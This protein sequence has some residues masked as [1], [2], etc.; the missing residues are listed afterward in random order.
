MMP[1]V[2]IAERFGGEL[3]LDTDE[4]NRI[5]RTAPI[6]TRDYYNLCYALHDPQATFGEI[7]QY[8]ESVAG[9][10]VQRDVPESLLAITGLH[11][12]VEEF[13]KDK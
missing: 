13:L 1:N 6:T 3:G 2:L 12:A 11:T 8:A 10:I 7:S 4:R 5:F 9:E